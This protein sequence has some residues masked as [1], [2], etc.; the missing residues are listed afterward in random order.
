VTAARFVALAPPL[1]RAGVLRCLDY[2][3]ER[4]PSGRVGAL[5]DEALVEARALVRARGAWR[6]L[7]PG[8]CGEVGLPTV[9]AEG[10]VLGLV[11]LGAAL[12]EQV[13]SL[14][15]QGAITHA[16]LLDACGSSAAEE[17]ADLLSLRVLDALG[18]RA[19]MNPAP[20]DGGAGMNPAPTDG[21]AGMNTAPTDG[22]AGM[23]TA[24]T[25]A[26]GCRLS[27]GYGG[28]GL[29][30]QPALLARLHAGEL[31]ITLS[32]GFM[33]SP[34]KSISFAMWLG[35]RERPAAGLAGCRACGLRRC[36]YALPPRNEA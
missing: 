36:R 31:E 24:S 10:L 9:P 29:E 14:Q 30:H 21:G 23:N 22:G 28:W 12:E 20:T 34:R 4:E 1:M 15:A 17:A 5:L 35:A 18:L 27:P 6:S 13:A 7:P 33:M 19:G 32:P 2:P 16:L 8:R 26:P 25:E 3:A 11:T